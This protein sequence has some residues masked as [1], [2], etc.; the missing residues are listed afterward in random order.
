MK[1]RIYNSTLNQDLWNNLEFDKT[2][3][4]QLLKI[5]NDFYK[6]SEL[7]APIKDIILLGSNTN[8][9]WTPFSDLDTHIVI[10]FNELN[11]GEHAK[12]LA[13]LS[14]LKWKESHNIKIKGYDVELYIQDVNEPNHSE[15]SFSL[16]KNQW[17]KPPVK[18]EHVEVNKEYIKQKFNDIKD[19]INRVVKGDCGSPD[20][21]YAAA[22][23]LTDD[24]KQMRQAGLDKGGEL[25]EE[26]I[27]FKLLRNTKYLEKLFASKPKFYDAQFKE[28]KN[29]L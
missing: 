10:D 18:K 3:R 28:N 24:I 14:K 20:Q 19:R 13:D 15:A 9:N 8:Y 27:V 22:E 7:Q 6:D 17:I 29:T 12:Q 1:F 11:A 23:K 25:S 2:V 4:Y 26:N 21:C 5:A 16:L